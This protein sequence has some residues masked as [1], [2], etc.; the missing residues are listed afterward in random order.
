MEYS[1]VILLFF[2]FVVLSPKVFIKM[3]I[4]NNL[5][6]TFIH[7]LLLV[8]LLYIG[9]FVIKQFLNKEG[10]D[11]IVPLGTYTDPDGITV[12]IKATL[13]SGAFN[14]IQ[15]IIDD[16]SQEQEV[17][18]VIHNRVL[19]DHGNNVGSPY[20]E[21]NILKIESVDY[22]NQSEMLGELNKKN[23][24]LISFSFIGDNDGSILAIGSEDV[25]AS[26]DIDIYIDDINNKLKVDIFNNGFANLFTIEPPEES[27]LTRYD[28]VKYDSTYNIYK[29][30]T[31]QGSAENDANID[32]EKVK[33]YN[34]RN[35]SRSNKALLNL[36][37]KYSENPID[38]TSAYIEDMF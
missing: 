22:P 32:A 17:V 12:P 1:I 24:M 5:L 15:N 7:G 28:I 16:D 25:N 37:V 26:G 31:L 9:D 20:G 6:V 4:K 29:N 33:I 8:V 23:N 21:S 38:I 13:S 14:E 11:Y 19:S 36:V 27:S 34:T 18:H 10:L 35:T 2:L 3:N 30:G